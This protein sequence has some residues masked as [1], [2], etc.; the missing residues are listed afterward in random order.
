MIQQLLN[1]VMAKYRDLSVSQR[2]LL[3]TD[4]SRYFAQ[5]RPIIVN[6]L[7][8]LITYISAIVLIVK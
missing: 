8:D 3:A 2:H 5:P 4:K 6:Y 1:S 7:H